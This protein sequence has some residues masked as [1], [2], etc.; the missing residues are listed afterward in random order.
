M[1]A[2]SRVAG[3]VLAG[4]RGSRLGASVPKPLVEIAGRPMIAYVLDRFPAWVS[5]VV[6]GA[7]VAS[8]FAELGLPVIPDRNGGHLGP[9]AALD[10]ASAWLRA[11]GDAATHLLCMPGDT[12]FLPVDVAVRMTAGTA[13]RVRFAR[14]SGDMQPTVSLWPL[15]RLDTLAGRLA[16]L[17][18]RSLLGFAGR[19]EVEPV[20]FPPSPVAPNADPFFNVNTPGELAAA[21]T[22]LGAA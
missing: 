11:Q 3:L 1:S 20:D 6:L 7:N 21:R 15:A 5:P 9:L 2:A 17:Q 18:D 14:C 16:D 8:S 12:P 19:A 22:A 10:A 4:G 13:D